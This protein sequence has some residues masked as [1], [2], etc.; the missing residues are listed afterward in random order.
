MTP[1]PV[2][3]KSMVAWSD[4]TKKRVHYL[5][6]V[7]GLNMDEIRQIPILPVQWL[8]Y[9]LDGNLMDFP[10]FKLYDDEF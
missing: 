9:D 6:N 8:E 5:E 10:N 1:V 3:M 4:L 7:V 2:D